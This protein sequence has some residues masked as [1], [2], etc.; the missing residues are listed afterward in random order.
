MD[1]ALNGTA[2]EDVYPN[3]WWLPGSGMQRGTTFM[4]DGDPLTPG[5]PSTEHAYRLKEEEADLP[6]IP[7]QPIG[8]DDAKVILEKMGGRVA[9]EGWRGGLKNV[10]YNLGP[11][12]IGDYKLRLVTHN[13]IKRQRS[14]N[15]ISTV[16]GSVE[17]D[18]Y[19][20]IGNHR[21]AWGYGA[22]DPSSGTAQLIET[23]RVV[24]VL[25]G[26]GWRPRR[27]LVFCSWGAE[28]YGL[29]GSTEWVEEHLTKL[30]QRAVVYINADTC[31]RGTMFELK[32]SPLTWQAIT[33]LTKL[34]P[35]VKQ[36]GSLYREWM[37]YHEYWNRTEPKISTLGSGSDYAPFAFYAGIPSLMMTFTTDKR[38]YD[39]F[40][41]YYHTGYETFY[42][43]DKIVDPGFKITQGCS[44]IVG[45]ALRYF[46]DSHLLP[47]HLPQ[48]P[49][50]VKESLEGVKKDYHET[51]LSIYP[52]F[53][54]LEEA[55]DDLTD[56]AQLFDATLKERVKDMDPVTLRAV[57]DQVMKI[58]QLFLLPAGLPGRPDSRHAVFAPSQF[59]N[60]A[61]A[62]FPGLLDLLYKID[63]L[64]GQE[65][66]DREEAIKK[67]VS[68]LTILMHAAAKFL[69]DLHLI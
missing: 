48:L 68:Q 40:F 24:G 46:A 64:Q 3:S 39:V 20:L 52:K 10:A 31:T 17:P 41:P 29:I 32:A 33:R 57:N 14:F 1:V 61:A 38:K 11:E 53:S 8:Y 25:L 4:G 47:F 12:L 27:T 37:E 51:L 13:Y 9:P 30:Q 50:T 34:M 2:P 63:T 21:D 66:A 5:W 59:N 18:R 44:R 7:C 55:V 22:S 54:L 67:H 45:L 62:G 49:L 6:T 60:Y 15:V 36:E 28:E 69:K 26:Q 16:K 23:A 65:R 35:A 19:V 58:E 43:L 56:A 42:M